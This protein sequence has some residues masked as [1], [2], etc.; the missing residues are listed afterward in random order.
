MDHFK[1]YNL[2]THRQLECTWQICFLCGTLHF[3]R[4]EQDA[5]NHQPTNQH[6]YNPQ[7]WL[8]NI[9]VLHW[10]A[11]AL[12]SSWC[13]QDINTQ[14][15]HLDDLSWI[16]YNINYCLLGMDFLGLHTIWSVCYFMVNGTMVR[17]W[18]PRSLSSTPSH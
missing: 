4:S 12:C 10:I 9:Q 1:R 17:I 16:K 15:F 7:A 5:A 2:S 14:N 3:L 6:Y 13:H 11:F 8:H 18:D